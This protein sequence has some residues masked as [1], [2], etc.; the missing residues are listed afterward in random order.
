MTSFSPTKKNVACT[1]RRA[2]VSSTTGVASGSGPLSKLSVR[3]NAAIASM[4]RP[5]QHA[6]R[7]AV[8]AADVEGAEHDVDALPGERR[9]VR[10]VLGDKDALPEQRV[11]HR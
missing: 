11:M 10:H 1:P 3:S 2:S 8:G 7:R 4:R 9:D 5:R 6:R